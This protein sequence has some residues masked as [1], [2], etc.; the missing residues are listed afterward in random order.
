MWNLCEFTASL[1]QHFEH[2]CAWMSERHTWKTH[3]GNGLSKLFKHK[4]NKWI[5]RRKSN[6]KSRR[7]PHGKYHIKSFSKSPINSQKLCKY[8]IKKNM[9]ELFED[10]HFK[11]IYRISHPFW[12]R[13]TII[14][15]ERRENKPRKKAEITWRKTCRIHMLYYGSVFFTYHCI[16]KKSINLDF[17]RILIL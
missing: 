9:Q 16:L 5:S 2:T 10:T 1:L 12:L 4:T 14:R 17:N 15:R 6:V 3:R 7:K 8:V 11:P 13:E